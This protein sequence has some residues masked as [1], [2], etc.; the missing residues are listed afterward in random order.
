MEGFL[1]RRA[2]ISALASAWASAQVK[3]LAKARVKAW[4]TALVISALIA[5]MDAQAD[6]SMSTGPT[7]SDTHASIGPWDISVPTIHERFPGMTG[8]MLMQMTQKV[9]GMG[10]ST[11]QLFIEGHRNIFRHPFNDRDQ[12]DARIEYMEQIKTDGIM[13]ECRSEII[14]IL[15]TDTEK[16]WAEAVHSQ[17]KA[18]T[19]VPRGVM[20]GSSLTDPDAANHPRHLYLIAGATLIEAAYMAHKEAPDSANVKLTIKNGVKVSLLEP[21]TPPDVVH[22]YVGELNQR[23]KV[24]A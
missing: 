18:A 12:E 19:W 16:K 6:S 11:Q 10:A 7:S 22:Y 20:P 13:E 24:S 8:K 23:N 4:N 2:L 17:I 5:A 1:T 15:L 14:G 9:Y 3:A 21:R